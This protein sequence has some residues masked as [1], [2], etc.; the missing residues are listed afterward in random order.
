M[1]FGHADGQVSKAGLSE[2]LE[3]GLCLRGEND[4]ARA[5]DASGD[6]GEL[7]HDRGGGLVKEGEG[8]GLGGQVIEQRLGEIN[9]ALATGTK[10][11]GDGAGDAT[12][13]AEGLDEVVIGGVVGVKLV[14]GH[15]DRA[16]ELGGG[17]EMSGEVFEAF[18]EGGGVGLGEGVKGGATVHFEGADGGHQ[19]DGGG[20]ESALTALD[21]DEF[22]TAEVEGKAAFGHDEVG[23]GEGHA[24]GND[25]VAAVGN[26]GKGAAVEKGGHAL[27]GLDEVGLDGVPQ[28]RH[29]GA[30]NAEFFGKDGIARSGEADDDAVNTGAQVG[31][32]FGQAEN[33][34]DLGGGGDVEAGL[35]LGGTAWRGDDAAEGA[36]VDIHDAL[37]GDLGGIQAAAAL[38]EVVVD[39]GGQQIVRAGDR[40]EVAGEVKVD[41]FGGLDGAATAASGT[42]FAA[43]DGTH[44][45]LT[46]GKGDTLTD[47]F[48]ALGESNGDGGLAFTGEGGGDGGDENEAPV[49][50]A[51][52]DRIQRDFGFVPTVGD[53]VVGREGE[54]VGD[55]LDVRE[56]GGRGS[57]Q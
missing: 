41:G 18:F 11:V 26:V 16:V 15:D 52:A 36:V 49:F 34:H 3:A 42:T 56:H 12:G 44:G 54:R 14:E 55:G 25:G 43:E 20:S 53:E 1:G 29:E 5:V 32:G 28:E 51:G 38:V 6:G 50:G 37:P 13:G 48:Q 23:V 22:F 9:R 33:G 46:Q 17:V 8:G 45:G 35:A 39:D 10:D 19:D 27:D 2:L 21:V 7:L 31:K 30:G 24:G 4:A 47:F 40:M 57:G